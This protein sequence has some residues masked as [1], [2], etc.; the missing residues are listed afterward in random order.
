LP[1]ASING[2]NMYY[3]VHG[4]GDPVI[5]VN[6]VFANTSSW[7]YQKPAFLKNYQVILYDMRGQGQTDHPEDKYSFDLHVEDQ[8]AL[9]DKLQINCAHHV[10][11]SYGAEVGLYFALKYP[12]LTKSLSI[13]CG[14]TYLEP[15]Q[16]YVTNLWRDACVSADPSVFFHSTVPFNFS[17]AF[18]NNNQSL[19]EEAKDRYKQFDYPAFVRL[20]DSFLEIDITPEQLASIDIPS[21]IIGGEKDLIKPPNPYSQL[22]HE[23]I[24]ESEY[25]VVLESGHVIIWEKPVEFNNIIARFLEKNR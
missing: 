6:G 13:C 2:I 9:L 4:E 25:S 19:F 8:K 12:D 17:P 5:F 10:G 21:C 7:V 14:L 16:K 23:H 22:M 24:P 18:V 11:I 3:E 15:Y 1:Y 20:I